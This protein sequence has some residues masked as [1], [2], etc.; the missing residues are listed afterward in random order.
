MTAVLNQPLAIGMM[1]LADYPELATAQQ[2]LGLVLRCAEQGVTT[3]DHADIYGAG[4]CEAKFGE[5]LAIK[6]SVRSQLTLIS[7]ADI[8]ARDADDSPWQVKHYN[9]SAEYLVQ[10]VDASLRRL[11]TDYLDGF[12]L[13]RPDPLM[14]VDEL[15]DVLQGLIA[16]G[17]VRWV[18][19]SNFAPAHWSA[20][21]AAVPLRCNQ[22]ELSLAAQAAVWDGQLQHMA[23]KGIQV[24]AWSPLAGGRFSSNLKQAL[25]AVAE[26]HGATVEQIALAWVRALPGA[27]V[28]VLGSLRWQRISDA[29][30]ASAL[31]LSRQEWFY[32][33][34]A[35]RGHAVA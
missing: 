28:C 26:A 32:L 16:S 14:R 8:V 30:S 34:E 27:P 4:Q 25:Q 29:V 18:G 31:C 9:S 10:Q 21:A 22:I 11:R 17:K 33:A 35:A 1:R 19:V 20:L 6:P 3:F 5:A 2:L 12:L 15:A 7:K 24:M 13:H 23:A